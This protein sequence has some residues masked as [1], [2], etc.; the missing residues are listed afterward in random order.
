[1]ALSVP[2]S[3]FTSR[4]GGGSAF[5][6]RRIERMDTQNHS[7]V[8][9]LKAAVAAVGS[10]VFLVAGVV[11]AFRARHYQIADQPMPNGKGGSMSSGDGYLIATV[12]ILFSAIWFIAARR[13][14]RA[15]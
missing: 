6:V 9:H 7:P 1:L 8:S 11:V 13:F 3:R 2:L 5:Y 4:V 12:L 10:V 15:R 14:Y